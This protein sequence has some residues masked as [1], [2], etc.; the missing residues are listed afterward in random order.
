LMNLV[1][2]AEIQAVRQYLFSPHNKIKVIR[3]PTIV[4]VAHK[5]GDMKSTGAVVS[6]KLENM[7][8]LGS[9][10]TRGVANVMRSLV[11]SKTPMVTMSAGNFGRS[12]AFAAQLNGIKG[13]VVM[14][15]EVPKDRVEFIQNHG[16]QVELCP[17]AQI[18]EKVD[19]HVAN[20]AVFSHPFDDVKL[21]AGYGSIGLEIME[22]VPD[23]D[24]VVVPVGGGGLLSGILTA[25]RHTSRGKQVRVVGVEPEGAQKMFQSLKQGQ[26][27]SFKPST[28]AHGLAAPFAGKITFEHIQRQG[29][30][31]VLVSDEEIK[32]AL[33]IVAKDYKVVAETSGVAGVA[34]LLSGKLGDVSGKK[35]VCVISGGNIEIKDL[36][37]YVQ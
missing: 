29:G 23:V 21:I 25:I 32:H 33:T 26:A 37:G 19:C 6:L 35:V 17:P 12:F 20:G 22:D 10:K 1:D 34:A 4:D 2:G 31:I 36:A 5:N 30:E 14:P 7:Q 16:L 24:I 11:G 9:F 3:T 13:T 18:M 28:I 8:T 15:Q 27:V